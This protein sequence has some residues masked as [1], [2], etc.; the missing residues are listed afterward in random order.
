MKSGCVA[1]GRGEPE[2]YP[3]KAAK[4]KRPV[5]HGMVFWAVR[6]DGRVMLR[7]RPEQGLL[8][9]MMEFPSTDWRKQT[10]TL[11]EARKQAPV[12][13]RWRR[14]DGVVRHTFT[15]FHL[16]LTVLSAGVGIKKERSGRNGALWSKP[17]RFSDYALPTLMKK[18][19]NHVCNNHAGH[20]S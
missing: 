12:K 7:K 10:W 14:L 9:G 6:D 11:S 16:E 4:A 5:R 3:E 18:V 20:S 8:G 17:S 13:A 1:A 2:R 15:H 19:A